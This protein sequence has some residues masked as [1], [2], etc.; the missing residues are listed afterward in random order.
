MACLARNRMSRARGLPIRRS[1]GKTCAEVDGAERFSASCESVFREGRI[2][3]SERD[4][5][6]RKRGRGKQVSAD[7]IGA[8]AK[9]GRLLLLERGNPKTTRRRSARIA[10]A[11]SFGQKVCLRGGTQNR[12]VVHGW[13]AIARESGGK[14]REISDERKKGE[15]ERDALLTGTSETPMI[16]LQLW[17]DE[18]VFSSAILHEDST[19]KKNKKHDNGK[20]KIGLYYSSRVDKLGGEEHPDSDAHHFIIRP[21][22]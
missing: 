4:L 13:L 5:I 20:R 16:W 6:S 2:G 1:R 12:D 22:I 11:K 19:C 7:Q 10:V 15:W 17:E 14:L 3:R 9:Q 21:L 18:E 8:T